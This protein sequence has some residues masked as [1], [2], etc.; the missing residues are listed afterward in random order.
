MMLL[1]G[2]KESLS[3]QQPIPVK[4]VSYDVFMNMLIYIYTDTFDPHISFQGLINLL[5][6]SD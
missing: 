5:P 1:S 4:D 3:D 6:L 2:L